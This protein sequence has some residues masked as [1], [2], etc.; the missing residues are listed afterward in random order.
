MCATHAVAAQHTTHAHAHGTRTYPRTSKQPTQAFRSRLCTQGSAAN[1]MRK[2]RTARLRKAC[3][4]SS[5]STQKQYT[6]YTQYTRYTRLQLKKNTQA[7]HA[8]GIRTPYVHA[9]ST[10]TQ[11][12]L[13]ATRYTQYTRLQLPQAATMV[14]SAGMSRS[15]WGRGTLRARTPCK[16]HGTD[17]ICSTRTHNAI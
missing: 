14:R 6:Q 17:A 1:M 16:G 15:R 10:R 4:R 5:R 3:F 9:R 11:Y 8:S 12:T 7:G 2:A 13:D